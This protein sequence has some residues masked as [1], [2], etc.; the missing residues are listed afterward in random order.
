MGSEM[1]IRDSRNS[2]DAERNDHTFPSPCNQR[3]FTRAM[4]FRSW[5][6]S[7]AVTVSLPVRRCPEGGHNWC[8]GYLQYLYFRK[9]RVSSAE[10]PDVSEHPQHRRITRTGYP[11]VSGGSTARELSI[12]EHV[13]RSIAGDTGY[14]TQPQ[15]LNAEL[16]SISDHLGDL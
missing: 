11:R 14:S 3:I 10:I 13:Q 12:S 7:S 5:S 1:C 4:Q 8:C 15:M 9:P 16:P 2:C 6:W